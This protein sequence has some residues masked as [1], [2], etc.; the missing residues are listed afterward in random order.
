MAMAWDRD[1]DGGRWRSVTA[2]W[3]VVCEV[4]ARPELLPPWPRTATGQLLHRLVNR[5]W[6]CVAVILLAALGAGFSA[7]LTAGGLEAFNEELRSLLSYGGLA[8]VAGWVIEVLWW[9]RR[10]LVH[11]GA[12]GAHD[13]TEKQVT[14]RL[15]LGAIGVALAVGMLL[16]ALL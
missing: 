15:V 14:E 12:K 7:D 6:R 4:N 16:S 13:L 9:V 1:R 2:T 10:V 5:A 11:A 8:V 3:R